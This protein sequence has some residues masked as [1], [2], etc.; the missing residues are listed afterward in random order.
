MQPTQAD[1]DALAETVLAFVRKYEPDKAIFLVHAIVKSI[2]HHEIERD[3]F[4]LGDE[5]YEA[6]CA[7][8][9]A[10]FWPMERGQA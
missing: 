5:C 9:I 2:G 4:E 3:G 7:K 6:D 1:C 10:H 8:V